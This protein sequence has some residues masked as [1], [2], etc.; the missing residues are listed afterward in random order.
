MALA[1]LGGC[2]NDD[3]SLLTAEDRQAAGTA[4][5][6]GS[7]NQTS[8]PNCPDL[9]GNGVPDCAETLVSN[10]SFDS[11]V[12]HWVAEQNVAQSW[13][14]SDATTSARSGSLRVENSLVGEVPTLAIAGTTQ[15]IA[16]SGGLLI[17]AYVQLTLASGGAS[18]SAA[19]LETR[20]YSSEDCTGD[21][22]MSR[23]A[24]AA[25]SGSDWLAIGLSAQSPPATRSVQVR[26]VAIKPFS[27]Q[28][29]AVLFDNVLVEAH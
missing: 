12:S 7:S 3:R 14:S 20:F 19:A 29:L 8:A 4:A 5:T 9:D 17:D 27:E 6:A 1:V 10:P 23:G 11:D 2:V 25:L 28:P 18:E 21:V 16:V 24:N 13:S 26:L 22:E 15:C